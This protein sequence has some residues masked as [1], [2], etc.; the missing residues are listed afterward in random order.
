MT[1]PLTAAGQYASAVPFLG[2]GD[3]NLSSSGE[4]AIRIRAYKLYE[5]FYHNRPETF[6]VLLRGD[7]GD[8]GTPIYIPSARK[9]VDAA[10]RFLAVDFNYVVSP[11]SGSDSDRAAADL[12]L[13][14]LFA[15]ER[16]YSKFGNQRRYSLIRGDSIWHIVGDPTKQPGSRLSVYEL[17]PSNYFAIEN[18]DNPDSLLGCHIVDFVQDPKKPDDRTAK[19]VR[20]QTYLRASAVLDPNGGYFV[21]LGSDPGGWTSSLTFWEVGK[22]DDR[23]LKG[24]DLKPLSHPSA[25]PQFSLPPEI[26]AMPV[27]HWR[28]N[29]IPGQRFGLSELSGVE[30]I[31]NG[32]NQSI[33]DEDLTLVMQGLGM[34]WTNAA[35]PKNEDGSAGDWTIGPGVVV[36]VGDDNTF[37]RVTG[38]SSVA[39]FQ[40]HSKAMHDHMSQ[41]LGIPDIAQG[42]VDV[43]VAESGISLKLQLL[44]ILA[45][46]GE[47]ELE[48][49]GMHDQ[50]FYDL[51]TMW[52][53]VIEGMNF[54]DVRV[55]SVVG[56][57]MP[58]NREARIQ[59]ILLV[60]ASGLITIA[61]AQAQLSQFGYEF[62]EG[63]DL[64]VVQEAAAIAEAQSGDETRSRWAQELENPKKNWSA[65]IGQ[66]S[67]AS[68]AVQGTGAPSITT[69]TNNNAGPGAR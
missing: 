5:D 48:I 69:V 67:V 41:A 42:R 57:P 31:I 62:D 43:T 18:P 54:P 45:N 39:P 22:W 55:V 44:P 51:I 11:K 10:N 36:E 12:Q 3:A 66:S 60:Q 4:D 13:Y 59:E 38:V 61:Q 27:Y 19:I 34:Y 9:M 25:K 28:N 29:L 26:T 32:I 56:D 23:H 52:Y 64:R 33:T 17:N 49:L 8:E 7:E 21:P 40:D 20:R 37:G 53:P 68:A 50:M 35:P 65:N 30:T 16:F 24:S 58:I 2:P 15:R 1:T 6:K 14:N 63:D 47:K 46:N